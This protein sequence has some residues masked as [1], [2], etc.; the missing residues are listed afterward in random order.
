MR[1]WQKDGWQ[2]YDIH[3]GRLP[4]AEGHF[5]G[6]PQRNA[7]IN[8]RGGN[9]ST[10]LAVAV[11][12]GHGKVAELLLKSNAEIELKDAFGSSPLRCAVNTHSTEMTH[13]L[14]SYNAGVNTRDNYGSTPL[15]H[16]E[17]TEI[18]KLLIANKADVNAR[19]DLSGATPLHSAAAM[20]SKELT[21][22]LLD[23][24]AIINAR[25]KRGCTPLH[26]AV[27]RGSKAVVELLL[28]S[29]ADVN[30]KDNDGNTPLQYAF[31]DK[32]IA[33]LLR[34]HSGHGK[35]VTT[36][37]LVGWYLDG[38]AE[39]TMLRQLLMITRPMD[40]KF[41]R[42]VATSLFLKLTFMKT[43]PANT[44]SGLSLSRNYDLTSSTTSYTTPTM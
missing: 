3:G 19:D 35:E 43:A 4:R 25:D 20:R 23:N 10:P 5:W 42:K 17:G 30:A 27:Q 33:P 1:K 38:D 37:P 21:Q 39:S 14:L 18:A 29:K 26:I 16:A 44:P 6:Q 11:S 9:A 24:N 34:Q 32:E 8:A 40:A 7:N 15:A 28:A 41:G 22:V 31:R 13:L 2:K 36:K 12:Y